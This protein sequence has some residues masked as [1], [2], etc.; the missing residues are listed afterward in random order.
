MRDSKS[1][2]DWSNDSNRGRGFFG[3][4]VLFGDLH[5]LASRDTAKQQLQTPK[6]AFFRNHLRSAQSGDNLMEFC[7]CTK[8]WYIVVLVFFW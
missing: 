1:W 3:H 4:V 2:P 7:V 5:S 6:G 8:A